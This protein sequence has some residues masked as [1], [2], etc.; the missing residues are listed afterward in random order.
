MCGAIYKDLSSSDLM[1]I[2]QISAALHKN[3]GKI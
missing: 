1:A 3:S 2:S